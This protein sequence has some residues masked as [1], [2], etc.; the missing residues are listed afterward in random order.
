MALFGVYPEFRFAPLRALFR[1]TLWVLRG[2]AVDV[3]YRQADGNAAFD[4]F[5]AGGAQEYSP[6]WSEA[7]LRGAIHQRVR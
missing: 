3:G 7:Q 2:L 5:S 6:E 4:A 1:R